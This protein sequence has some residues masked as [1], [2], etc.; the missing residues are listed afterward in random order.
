MRCFS[1]A[2]GRTLF[3]AVL[4][5]TASSVAIAQDT[6]PMKMPPGMTPAIMKMMMTPGKP[7]PAGLPAGVVPLMGCIPSMGYHYAKAKDEPFGPFYGYYSG[8]PVFTEIMIS[9]TQ[10]AGGKSWDEQLKPLPGYTINHVDIWW[11][12]HGHPG[13]LVPHY[14]VHAWYV[15][16]A[17][18]MKYCG[19]TSGKKPAFL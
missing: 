18:H 2:S 1:R 11:E 5:A 14:D 15:P 12:P 13:Y 9:A 17:E 16:H 10:F 6:P 4:F 8:K 19:N 7:H 3:A